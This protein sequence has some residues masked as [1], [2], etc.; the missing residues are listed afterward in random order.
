[1]SNKEI[2]IWHEMDGIG[3]RSLDFLQE[4]TQELEEKEGLKFKLVKINIVPF[5][6]K[7]A[8]IDKEAE[9]PDI[10]LIAQ[11]MVSLGG[12]RLQEIPEKFS[13]YMT[14]PIWD[15]MKYE[16]VQRGIPHLQ[17]NHAIVYY[18]KKYFKTAP[19]TWDDIRAFQKEGVEQIAM[20]LNVSYWLMP[21]VYTLFGNP[22]VDG[23]VAI[24]KENTQEVQ[25][26]LLDLME[27]GVLH[28][29]TAVTTMLEKFLNGELAC[30]INGE[31]VYEYIHRHMGE[32]VGICE[33]P[34]IGETP[35]TGLSSTIGMAFPAHTLEGE[36]AEG[37][38]KFINYMLSK[39]VQEKWLTEHK[40]IPVNEEILENMEALSGDPNML[41]SYKQ[42]ENNYFIVN[43]PCI[44]DL[45][46]T[47]KEILDKIMADYDRK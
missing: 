46:D 10:M 15:S 20:D 4:I 17:G 30:I 34:M 28:S 8:N 45:W 24:T 6:E 11:D 31:W 41:E 3:D 29:Y 2:V 37:V 9:Q 14:K 13:K 38:E 5:I 36:K 40:R 25:K 43:E 33:L 7:I 12:D 32:D 18:N 42:M 27:E 1:M 19:K 23:K 16:G 47:G 44:N 22:I 39:P 35:I 21:F 26:F